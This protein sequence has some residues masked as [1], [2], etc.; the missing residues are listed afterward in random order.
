M[1]VVRSGRA[2]ALICA[3]VAFAVSWAGA[4]SSFGIVGLLA[5]WLPAAVLALAA[6]SLAWL[7]WAVVALTA[8]LGWHCRARERSEAFS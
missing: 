1:D 3:L 8:L 4:I 5:G 6:A 2:L 7:A